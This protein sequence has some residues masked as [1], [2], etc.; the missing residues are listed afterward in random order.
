MG[1]TIV[2]KKDIEYAER[3]VE[4]LRYMEE[5]DVAESD[6]EPDA[7]QSLEELL[8]MNEEFNKEWLK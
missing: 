1:N 3:L 7:F 8:E 4:E 2:N 6:I 5:N